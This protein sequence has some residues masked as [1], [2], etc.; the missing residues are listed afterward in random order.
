MASII[1]LSITLIDGRPIIPSANAL[2]MCSEKYLPS[3]SIHSNVLPVIL[4]HGYNEPPSVWS[5]WEERLRSDG[6]PFCTVYYFFGL[7]FRYDQ[8]GSVLDHSNDLAQIVQDVRNWTLNDKVNMVGHSK[9]G[10]DARVYLANSGTNAV[11]N[12]IMIGT[13]NGGNPLANELVAAAAKTASIFLPD[14]DLFINSS[15]RPALDNLAIGADATK[16]MENESTKY[17]TIYGDWNP[18][19]PCPLIEHENVLYQELKRLNQIPNDG[20]VPVWSVESHAFLPHSTLIGHTQHCQT[21]Q[22]TD[23]EYNMAKTKVLL[24]V[25]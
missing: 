9:G 4:I 24:T 25:K 11:A 2:A 18:S 13:P 20:I 6:I 19:L 5:H 23:E 17:Y 1:A 3:S 15:C 10:L 14:F 16:A 7:Q 8:C 21:G 12:L 22:L